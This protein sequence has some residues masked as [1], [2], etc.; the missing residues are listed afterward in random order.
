MAKLNDVSSAYLLRTLTSNALVV[1][2]IDLI[3]TRAVGVNG[4]TAFFRGLKLRI[5]SSIL[6]A[7]LARVRS[8]IARLFSV[9]FT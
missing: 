1:R 2:S 7:V 8:K 3:F 5:A 4:V 6:F 9:A